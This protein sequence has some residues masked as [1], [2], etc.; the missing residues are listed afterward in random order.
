M[1]QDDSLV[2]LQC[3]KEGKKLRVKV[4]SPGYSPFA[5]CQFPTALRVEGRKFSI[6]KTDISI[7]NTKNKFFYRVKKDK[8]K[9]IDALPEKLEIKIE[10][11]YGDEDLSECTICMVSTEENPAMKFVIFSPCGHYV[12][13][14]ACGAKVKDCP[15]CRAKIEARVDRSQL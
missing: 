10:K 15:M 8:I 6:P 13:C 1:E 3:V 4:I 5:N 2:F 14:S 7:T 11:I 12:A 9:L